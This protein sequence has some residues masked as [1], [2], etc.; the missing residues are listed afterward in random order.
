MNQQFSKEDYEKKI[1]TYNT[2]D[3]RVLSDVRKN[4]QVNIY[5]KS[6]HKYATSNRITNSTGDYLFECKNVKQSFHVYESENS[7]YIVDAANLKDCYDAYE[8]AFNCEQQ[9]DCHAGN[10]LSYSKFS[11][12]SYDNHHIEYS[13]MCYG[14]SDLFGCVGLRDKRQCILNTQYTKEEYEKLIIKTKDQMRR[15][16]YLDKLARD[17]KYGEFFPIE[18]SPFAYNET[19]AQEYFPLN[20]EDALRRGF[21]WK[22]S[23]DHKIKSSKNARDLTI[24]QE[25]LLN[26]TF[27]CEHAGQCREQCTMAYRITSQELDIYKRLKVAIPSLCPNCRHYERLRQRNPMRLWKRQCT[28][29]GDKSTNGVY[30]NTVTHFHKSSSCP[31]TSS[32][33]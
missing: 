16:P 22:S 20:Q 26:E 13:E 2:S 21:G 4:F 8:P 24:A 7:A 25:L 15:I 19:V 6:I 10:R 33:D 3:L 30:I 11:S 12:V 32:N 27:A 17:Y 23:D 18:H 1:A 9:Y 28:C 5:G 29:G 14:S 31:N